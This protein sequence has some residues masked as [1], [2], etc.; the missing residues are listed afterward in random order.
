MKIKTFIVPP[1]AENCYLYYDENSK[2][3]VLI[4]PGGSLLEIMNYI[5][6]KGIQISRI[7]LTHGHYD[8]V[9]S[10]TKL[11]EALSTKTGSHSQNVKI[12]AHKDEVSLLSDPKLNLSVFLRD[13]AFSILVD[14]ALEDGAEIV[15]GTKN[16]DKPVEGSAKG[17]LLRVLH[18]PGHTKGCVCYYD[19][20]EGV[21]FS[22]DTL[23]RETV[24]RTDFPGGSTQELLS[25]I[26]K[27]F[28][29]PEDTAVY[30]GHEE[31]TS[32][33]HEKRHNPLL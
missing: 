1:L 33:G 11:K 23:F 19:P 14:E 9:G 18:T 31:A 10:V 20:Q 3:G 2:D 6:E 21:L 13:K 4:D 16:S 22:G 25:S 17:T 27:L 32:I 5:Q 30:P 26:E 28:T 12:C 8:H 24:G 29:L 7:L 15:L